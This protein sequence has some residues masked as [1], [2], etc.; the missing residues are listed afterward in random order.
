MVV[1]MCIRVTV[2]LSHAC[3]LQVYPYDMLAVTHRVRVKL[4]RDVDR[5][6]LE[7]IFY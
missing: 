7:V 6:R 5:T 2:C 1:Y 3:V 4:P